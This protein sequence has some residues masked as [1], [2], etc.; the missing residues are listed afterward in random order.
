M[1]NS[2]ISGNITGELKL[3]DDH[4]TFIFK[5]YSSFVSNETIEVEIISYEYI[6][7]KNFKYHF[8]TCSLDNQSREHIANT[9]KNQRLSRLSHSTINSDDK[10]SNL[11][12]KNSLPEGF[13]EITVTHQENPSPGYIF[14]APLSY[15][16]GSLFNII[17]EF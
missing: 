12:D 7:N 8:I 9:V 14:I 3:A 11:S 4:K 2:S 5:P 13:P 1:A 17:P 10:N 6:S 16:T 15:S